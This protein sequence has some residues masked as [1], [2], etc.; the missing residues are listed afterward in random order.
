[1]ISPEQLRAARA[2]LDVS[3]N[4][5][6]QDVGMTHTKLS[7][8]EKGITDVSASDMKVLHTYYENKGLEFT[9][10]HGVRLR[11][12]YIQRYSGADGFRSFM[13]DVYDVAKTVGGEICLYNARPANWI[14]WL[15]EE[16]N[17]MH[18]KRMAALVDKIDVKITAQYGDVQFIGHNHAEYRWI[19]DDM[20]NERSFY[21]YGDFIGFLIFREDNVS[22]FVMREK[23]VSE[24]FR[25]LFN[26][27]WDSVAIK[28]VDVNNV[29]EIE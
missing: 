7:R 24:S 16:W 8:L 22:I 14:K 17:A 23:E 26:I 11:Q 3:Q 29:G 12:T 27:A 18:S 13:D 25:S 9:D 20:W 21:A 4:A 10:G 28:P 19:P 15:G 2:I 6:A 1:M 5:V